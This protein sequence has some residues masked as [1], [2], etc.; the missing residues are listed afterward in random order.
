MGLIVAVDGGNTKTIA[1]VADTDGTIRG[2]ATAGCSDIY[3]ARS[4]EAGLQE[5][6][7]AVEGA[8]AAASAGSEPFAAS[9]FSLAG[10]DWPEDIGLLE[11]EVGARLA[12]TDPLVV[13]DAIGALRSGS[14]GWEGIA[15]VCGTFNAVGA[16]NADGR[17]F[18]L[19]FWP[20]RTG[21]AFDLST[22]ALRAV[23]REALGLGPATRADAARLGD[24]RRRRR[25][26]PPAPVHQARSPGLE[27]TGPH[28]P[29]PARRGR[30]G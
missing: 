21:G 20:D 6:V 25:D 14:P 19:G 8:V 30:R 29:G 1:V 4:V 12:V 9:V 10:A 5:L 16:R 11:H 17:V 15:V 3:G 28:G 26:R 22:A 24:V 7:A 2:V 18:H 23:Y 13:N 27:R